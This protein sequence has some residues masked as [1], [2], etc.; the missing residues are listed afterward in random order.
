MNNVN[1]N[2]DAATELAVIF[3][4]RYTKR[5][6]S[7]SE[8]VGSGGGMGRRVAS[9]SSFNDK[10]DETSVHKLYTEY[11]LP[12]A[13]SMPTPSRTVPP[14]PCTPRTIPRRNRTG[15]WEWE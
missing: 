13:A 7:P 9:S 10:D 14:P 12:F 6:S 11:T 8:K 2:D 4:T 15:E 3:S 1:Y 5:P